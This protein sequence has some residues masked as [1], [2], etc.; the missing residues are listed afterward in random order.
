M[1]NQHITP[2]AESKHE[3]A[4]LVLLLAVSVAALVLPGCA[5]SSDRYTDRHGVDRPWIARVDNHEP[6][7][8]TLVSVPLGSEGSKAVRVWPGL[9]PE[10]AAPPQPSLQPGRGIFL[11]DAR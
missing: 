5:T 11:G 7:G 8:L 10:K 4:N 3:R 9:L 2:V 6:A 1:N